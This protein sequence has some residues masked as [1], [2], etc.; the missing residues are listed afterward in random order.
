MNRELA[1]APRDEDEPYEDCI[2]LALIAIVGALG[3]AIG[4][5]AP[6]RTVEPSLG[7]LMLL[8]AARIL[9]RDVWR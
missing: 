1:T 3:V 5:C 4:V 9:V 2:V 6:E 7:L 8:L